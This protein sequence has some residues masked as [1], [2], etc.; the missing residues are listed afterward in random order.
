MKQSKLYKS[1]CLDGVYK[2]ARH[3]GVEM[4]HLWRTHIQSCLRRDIENQLTPED[5]QFLQQK[6]CLFCGRP[7]FNWTKWKTRNPIQYN[8]VDRLDN[9]KPYTLDNCVTCCKDCNQMKSKRGV[10]EFLDHCLR[11]ARNAE[12]L[13]AERS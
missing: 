11:V 2:Q 12:P 5:L 1:V 3:L 13:V 10:Q 7:P 9:S 6:E 8:G 4:A